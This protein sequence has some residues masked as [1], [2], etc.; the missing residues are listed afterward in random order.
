[1]END[2]QKDSARPWRGAKEQADTIKENQPELKDDNQNGTNSPRVDSASYYATIYFLMVERYD[3]KP[4][5]AIVT[6]VIAGLSKKKGFC[7]MSKENIGKITR[8]SNIYDV[9]HV[10]EK[11]EVIR[12]T[13]VGK[14][15]SPTRLFLT[16]K[17]RKDLDYCKRTVK[18][19][20]E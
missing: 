19:H 20:R 3:L 16:D 2:R 14:L 13:S 10:L 17:A 9:L 1:M 11:K 7:F 18:R 15:R 12:Q 6:H 4:N 5:E 8:V